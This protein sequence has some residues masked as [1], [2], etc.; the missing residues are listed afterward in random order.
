M[1]EINAAWTLLRDAA[2][3]AAWDR[4]HGV[5]P[6]PA[7]PGTA[8]PAGRAE[9]SAA[10][11]AGPQRRPIPPAWRPAMHAGQRPP[12]PVWRR[13]P[14]GEGAAGPPPGGARGSVLPFG[15]HIGWS[16]GEVARVD[17]G[18]L[19]WLHNRREGAP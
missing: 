16:L 13:G 1:A 18:Y 8:R 19:A 10:P 14:Y 12:V 9:R 6:H 15:R 5:T 4:A 11:S 7:R 17:P 3:R 2:K